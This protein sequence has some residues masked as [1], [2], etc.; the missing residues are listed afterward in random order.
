M[1]NIFDIICSY[2]RDKL[3][4]NDITHILDIIQKKN[5]ESKTHFMIEFYN[6]VPE[7]HKNAEWFTIFTNM[8][9][10][11]NMCR[12]ILET[13]LS[14]E[15][16]TNIYPLIM[17]K[18]YEYIGMYYN[19][20]SYG[21]KKYKKYVFILLDIIQY[22]I[23]KC[24]DSN[25]IRNILTYTFTFSKSKKYP[26]INLNLIYHGI[27]GI[28]YMDVENIEY[29][30]NSLDKGSNIEKLY[31]MLDEKECNLNNKIIM[32]FIHM[33][34]GKII[35]YEDFYKHCNAEIIEY[36]MVKINNNHMVFQEC[37][38][39]YKH[40]DM[41]IEVENICKGDDELI[42]LYYIFFQHKFYNA[43]KNGSLE[44]HL[45]KMISINGNICYLLN[46]A[47]KELDHLQT[48]KLITKGIDSKNHKY[49]NF[50]LAC[51]QSIYRF[52]AITIECIDHITKNSEINYKFMKCWTNRVSFDETV[53]TC[54]VCIKQM[55]HILPKKLF[56]RH[57]LKYIFAFFMSFSY[58]IFY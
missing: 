41:C 48:I 27:S 32:E 3:C 23:S 9:S 39:K 19:V 47:Y 25:Q 5:L 7:N 42:A 58:I 13:E 29:L 45:E 53:R 38:H 15:Q 57:V 16:I 14:L 46:D 12:F 22:Y 4:Q 31:Y 37:I 34:N 44:E 36:A 11:K 24:N 33:T 54:L 6:W 52:R 10:L 50:K 21:N 2:S 56:L 43:I 49:V 30:L 28:K 18:F 55:R 26:K 1:N 35:F 51:I 17:K 40:P 8:K 20:R